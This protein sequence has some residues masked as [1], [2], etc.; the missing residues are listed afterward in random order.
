MVRLRSK[1][2]DANSSLKFQYWDNSFLYMNNS[3][4]VRVIIP[5]E[6]KIEWLSN[7]SEEEKAIIELAIRIGVL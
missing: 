3:H 5:T 2:I 6:T 4:S 7:P 1:S